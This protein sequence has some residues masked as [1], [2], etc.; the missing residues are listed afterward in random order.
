M[1]TNIAIAACWIIACTFSSLRAESDEVI[2]IWPDT[3]PGAAR[4][5]GEEKDTSGPDAR[6]VAGKSVIRLGNVSV[7]QAHVYLPDRDKRNGSAVIVCPGG[8]FSILAWDLEGT[9][10]AEWFNSIGVTAVVLKYRVPTR[11]Q[12][13]RWLMPAMDAQRA[14]SIARSRTKEWKLNPDRIGILGFS[15]GGHT[16]A[17]TAYAQTRHYEPVDAADEESCTPNA[18]M[19]IY[20]AWLE[21]KDRNGLVED[22]VVNE[23]SP[24][25]FMVHAFDDRIRVEGPLYLGAALKKAGV[26]SE[27]HVY[28][29]GGHGYGLR[30]VD[31]HPVTTWPKR[32]ED[33]LRRNEW[34]K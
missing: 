23:S 3:P 9:E 13:P 7:P 20:A 1:P 30:P 25:T 8:G 22:L 29:T 21:N 16:A 31:A 17:R 18:A 14:I 32:C 11:D 10:V 33:W 24:P 28:D 2:N 4:D 6:T 19:L 15:A 27:I 5:V 12:D 26:A 34:I